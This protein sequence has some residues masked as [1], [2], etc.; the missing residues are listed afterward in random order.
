MKTKRKVYSYITR[1]KQL[2]VMEHP[3]SPEAGIQVP[4]GTIEPN[5]DP[6]HAAIREAEEETGLKSFQL[7]SLLGEQ[8]RDMRDYDKHEWHHRYF[9]H[10]IYDGGTPPR[11]RHTET[12]PSEGEQAHIILEF[13]WVDL[14]KKLPKLI[15]ELDF[16]L[17]DCL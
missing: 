2:L 12:T 8:V 7:V 1:G 13:Y 3:F 14:S 9:F 5:E 4:G 10:L 16:F 6:A 15:A 17:K 11:W